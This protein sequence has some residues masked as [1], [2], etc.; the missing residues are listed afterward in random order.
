MFV[1]KHLE[2]LALV[3]LFHTNNMCCYGN[4]LNILFVSAPAAGH[5]IPLITLANELKDR[6]HV[7]ALCSTNVERFPRNLVVASGAQFISAGNDPRTKYVYTIL[8]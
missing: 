7:T 6:G 8:Y 4:Q 5:I 3:I 1:N 2:F